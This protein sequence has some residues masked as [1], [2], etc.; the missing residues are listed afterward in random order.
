MYKW[1]SVAT[2]EIV[3]NLWQVIRVMWVDLCKFHI[4]N[5]RWEY[6]KNGF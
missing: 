5:F 2:G 3:E 4:I 1:Q 6:N